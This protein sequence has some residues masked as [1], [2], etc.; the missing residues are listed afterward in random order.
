MRAQRSLRAALIWLLSI[1]V[2]IVLVVAAGLWAVSFFK[3]GARA[4]SV[5]CTASTGAGSYSL[6]P[7]QTGNASL[8]TAISV[9][10]GL[11]AR[12]A[13]IGLAVALQESKLRNITHGDLDS[14]GLFQQRPSQDW[15][16]AEEILDPVYATNAFFNVLIT[17]NGYET[18]PITQAAQQVQRSAYP[19]A[20]AQR[21]PQGKAFASALSGLSPAALNCTLNPAT[22]KG[23]QV[24]VLDELDRAYGAVPAS[25][26]AGSVT[27]SAAGTVGWGYAQWAVANADSL[28]ITE[29]AFD[30]RTWIRTENA[31]GVNKGWQ[32]SNAAADQ[33]RITL[34]APT[35]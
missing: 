18:L 21:E 12:A 19:E 32:V 34:N 5:G 9:R 25:G 6:A 2:A 23:D 11:P 1:G 14:L 31:G 30:G 8:I 15:G 13:S 33:V 26:G 10:R 16:T 35:P 22:G 17:V 4:L 27:I 24:S 28:N 20:Y 7:D 29:V 3:P